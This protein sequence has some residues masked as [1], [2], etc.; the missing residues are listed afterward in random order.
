VDA[1]SEIVARD[2][3]SVTVCGWKGR[4]L[5][6]GKDQKTAA[7]VS[8][9]H[10]DGSRLAFV[11]S[12]RR[13]LRSKVW[14]HVFVM[15]VDLAPVVWFVSLA[16]VTC[17]YSVVLYGIEAWKPLAFLKRKACRSALS[18]LSISETTKLRFQEANPEV[19]G[20]CLVLRPS[21]PRGWFDGIAGRACTQDANILLSVGR[22]LAKERYKGIDQILECLAGVIQEV[23]GVRYVVVGDGD[24]RERLMRKATGL[25]L[26]QV[27]DWHPWVS[28]EE[29]IDLYAKCSLFVMPSKGEG[30]GLVYAEA[31][32]LGKPVVVGDGDAG[33]EFVQGNAAGWA[34][35]PDDRRGLVSTIVSW[36]RL[37]PLEKSR[38]STAVSGWAKSNLA[39]DGFRQRLESL[40]TE[41]AQSCR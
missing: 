11:L 36:F 30:F 6:E 22:M 37:S 10:A 4:L 21:L 20:S 7:N 26:G 28:E 24:D 23:P 29:L 40:L 15:H 12:V 33:R 14:R 32:S 34:V 16:Q 17:G 27:V 9:E 18:L 39:F 5:E 25:G 31:A 3:G 41:R 35:N 38:F 19:G 1:L 2:G 8:E 13:L